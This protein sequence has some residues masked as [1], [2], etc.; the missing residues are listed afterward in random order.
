MAKKEPKLNFKS[1][2]DKSNAIDEFTNLKN[3]PAWK[4]VIEYYDKKIEWL[5][6]II[7]GDITNDDGTGIIQ[8]IEELKL[9]RARRNMAQQF[10]NLPDILIEAAQAA[11]GKQIDF[12]P[13][14]E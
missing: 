9:F 10:R 8:T 12:D 3:H 11:E 2:A 4:R 1:K 14:D 5:E 6:K 7:D 13:Y